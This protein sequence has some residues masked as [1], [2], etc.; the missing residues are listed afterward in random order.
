M[1]QCQLL[2]YVHPQ[3]QQTALMLAASSGNSGLVNLL[4]E[5]GSNVNYRDK[6]GVVNCVVLLL[7]Y[8]YIGPH[9]FL[10][11]LALTV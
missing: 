2:Y 5:K 7:Y 3:N 6:V 10:F 11:V 8:S 1:T 9:A 4:L